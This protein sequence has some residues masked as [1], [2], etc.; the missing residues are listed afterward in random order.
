MNYWLIKS[1]PYKY[2]WDQMVADGSTYWD[3]VRSYPARVH[4][5]AMK[6]GDICLFYHSN[7]GKEIV[8][9]TRVI[10]EAYQDPTTEDE[11]WVAVDVEAIKPL[12][13]SV[14]LAQIKS[15][16]TLANMA[17]VKQARLSVGP[18]QEFEFEEIIKL[19]DTAF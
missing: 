8:G 16:D 18:V 19:S 12:N 14:T 13:K 2:S 6:N 4:L 15:N 7:E 3:G 9:I 1:E 5:R 11:K 17:L 10:K